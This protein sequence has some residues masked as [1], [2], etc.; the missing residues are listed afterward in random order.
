LPPHYLLVKGKVI[1]E[2]K[3]AILKGEEPDIRLE[4]LADFDRDR[5]FSDIQNQLDN[6]KKWF[7]T[8][9]IDLEKAEFEQKIEMPLDNGF[10]LVGKIDLL[11]PTH[12][13]DFKSGKRNYQLSNRTQ[14]AAYKVLAEYAGWKGKTV[15]NVFLGGDKPVE[16]VPRKA[17]LE[18]ATQRFWEL[19]EERKGILELIRKGV[20]VP[21]KVSM[22]CVWCPYRHLC[23]GV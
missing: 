22:D 10:S 18:K 9:E 19:L 21:C 11:T 8:T 4:D 5:L 15:M 1:H 14:L 2:A 17:T 6:L 7:E 12:I 16:Y 13:I 23:R 3:E 20:E